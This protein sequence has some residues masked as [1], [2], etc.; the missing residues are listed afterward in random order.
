MREILSYTFEKGYFNVKNAVDVPSGCMLSTSENVLFD[1]TSLVSFKG[2]QPSF[3]Y[4]GTRS[5]AVD[6]DTVVF[7][8]VAT[9]SAP[10]LSL[11]EGFGNAIQAIGKSLWFVGNELSDGMN[12][13]N[14]S[15]G[16]PIQIGGTSHI[17]EMQVIGTSVSLN[18]KTLTVNNVDDSFTCVAHGYVTG[19]KVRLT[20]VSTLPGGLSATKKYYAL[21]VTG[22]TAKIKLLSS[23][24]ENFY[25]TKA[26]TEEVFISVGGGTGIVS[27]IPK[28]G[29]SVF[30]TNTGGG[31][32]AGTEYGILDPVDAGGY[33]SPLPTGLN[34]SAY[35][36]KL[37]SNFKSVVVAPAV[38][39][40][41]FD[42][43]SHGLSN[44]DMVQIDSTGAYPSPFLPKTNYYVVNSNA[45]DFQLSATSGGGAITL[46][47]VGSGTITIAGG[48][49]L[50]ITSN[51]FNSTYRIYG[52]GKVDITSAETGVCKITRND[53]VSNVYRFTADSSTDVLTT[54][55]D[56]DT[57]VQLASNYARGNELRVSEVSSLPSGLSTT[58]LYRVL[59]ESA[60]KF[61]LT[62]NYSTYTVDS[63]SGNPSLTVT[64]GTANIELYSGFVFTTAAPTGFSANTVYFVVEKTSTT[65]KLSPD[66]IPGNAV[67]PSS[68][69]SST[70]AGG[71][72]AGFSDAGVGVIKSLSNPIIRATL[73]SDRFTTITPDVEVAEGDNPTKVAEKIRNA[74][75]SNVTV[76]EWYY[77]TSSDDKVIL[78]ARTP[79]PDSTLNLS[80]DK[81]GVT[82]LTN[83]TTSTA[84]QVGL[85]DY[86]A[87]LKTVPQ[88]CKWNGTYW[89]TPVQ[90]GLRAFEE[91][92][93]SELVVTSPLTRGS[94][95]TG[96]VIGSRTVRV[97]R[98][99]YG[100]VSIA[101]PSSNLITASESGD[102]LIVSIPP[103][104][105]DGSTKSDNSWYLYFTFAGLGST[106]THFLFPLEIPEDEL[107]GSASPVTRQTGNAKYRV[108]SQ[109]PS[110]KSSRLVEV[111]FLD[112]DLL[113]I[114]PVEDY[115]PAEPC[116]F[117]AKLGNS[118]CL[119]GTGEDLTGFDV[120]YPNFYEAFPPSWAD[121]LEEVP[122]SVATEQDLGFFWIC[123][124]NTSSIAQW[125]GVTESSAPIVLQKRS[126]VYGAIGEG[127]SV[128]VNGMLFLL[129]AG[130]TPVM[131]SPDGRADDN[132]GIPVSGF[133]LEAGN[134]DS[135]TEVSWDEETNSI[136]YACG[137]KALAYQLD[138][139]VWSAPIILGTTAAPNKFYDCT[140]LFG[141]NGNMYVCQFTPA[142]G[143]K[144]YKWHSTAN[145]SNT[146]NWKITSAFQFGKAF[147]S[148]KD[149][150][151]IEAI[152]SSEASSG[153]INFYAR[154]N[155]S[156]TQLSS[157]LASV[158]ITAAGSRISIREY[159]EEIDYDNV[160]AE[161]QGTRGGQTVHNV[162][163]TVETHK[164]E[165]TS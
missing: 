13:I 130:K 143:F 59:K 74:L 153:T 12:A 138:A 46:T 55:T 29:D 41:T 5:F 150:I 8:G 99:R 152:I 9:G 140:S 89:D 108:I 31:I 54:V 132:F 163:Y 131:L 6:R 88:F 154:K 136:I 17:E 98:K 2:L 116:K 96:L 39:T 90:V 114:A 24:F 36:V 83:V 19:D 162:I 161:I 1:S 57:A 34:A 95:F 93:K 64:G 66:T 122:V 106:S 20:A 119:I 113:P 44:G 126:S 43:T 50:P 71:S 104:D 102:S 165:R 139:R 7:F 52:G 121:W 144:T 86:Q 78:S 87:P 149:I 111:E 53:E 80:Y 77:V 82:G 123:T 33:E 49:V 115:F 25:E 81:L 148:L 79:L 22:E 3:N 72:F 47:S 133:F 120:S 155:Y 35:S 38:V 73:A 69:T 109:S 11:T 164:I 76:T 159:A 147:R 85:A 62:Q 141:L 129:S 63:T 125:T 58:V 145:L 112:N 60:D 75:R 14:T 156:L 160:S 51:V 84:T 127:A 42:K 134:F 10:T 151:Q 4:G 137:N 56:S 157:S 105:E 21:P 124:A 158:A 94:D 32:T 128:C 61:R 97:A 92:D 30:F 142:E 28:H 117:V 110:Q 26:T 37:T 100:T 16:L 18:T 65:I 70:I 118:L 67:T 15:T 91:A 45:N 107:D 135:K 101:S 27:G 40:N 146:V 103:Q 23:Y 48:A 68:T